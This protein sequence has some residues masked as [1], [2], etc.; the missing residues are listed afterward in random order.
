MPDF[1][2]HLQHSNHS[3][4]S[5]RFRA[6]PRRLLSMANERNDEAIFN[7]GIIGRGIY[8]WRDFDRMKRTRGLDGSVDSRT[9]LEDWTT[10]RLEGRT[11][12][13]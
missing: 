7:T 6:I 9:R 5:I 1:S 2:D 10:L 8:A 4:Y 13:D 3:A 11:I 12:D